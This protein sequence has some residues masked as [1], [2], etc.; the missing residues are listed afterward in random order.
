[1]GHGGPLLL[2]LWLVAT[3]FT[4][5][6]AAVATEPQEVWLQVDTRLLELRV[7]RG[8]EVIRRYTG[9][10]IGRSGAT[11][12][13]RHL[14]GKTPLGE[15]R[16]NRIA[17]D[18]PFH[19]FFGFDYPHLAQAKRAFEQGDLDAPAY[20]A[21]RQAIYLH[22]DPP[23]HTALGGFLGIHGIGRGD[24]KMHEDFNWTQGCIALT[25]EQIDELRQWV[26]LGT[27]VVVY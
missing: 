16:I 24:P 19:R 8:H 1:M 14:D 20:Q 21:I 22:R 26:R 2:S 6:G 17:D 12:D 7:L 18:S 27:R 25:N 5:A 10:A 13:K 9:I 11:A 23:Q 15:F 4:V 3:C